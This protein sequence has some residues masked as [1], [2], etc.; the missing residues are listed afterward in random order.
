M[1]KDDSYYF[2]Q[3]PEELC[4]KL[5]KEIPINTK[6]I[7]FE[8]F[9]GEGNFLKYFPEENSNILRKLKKV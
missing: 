9:K 7:L 3:T 5:I 1:V 8:P 2:H 4:E 6:D